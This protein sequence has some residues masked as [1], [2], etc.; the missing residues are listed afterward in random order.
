MHQ[1]TLK[2][3]PL[4]MCSR[5]GRRHHTLTWAEA[6]AALGAA[7]WEMAVWEMAVWAMAALGTAAGAVWAAAEPSLAAVAAVSS[8]AASAHACRGAPPR[9]PLCGVVE[10]QINE[11]QTARWLEK[12]SSKALT[13]LK[14]PCNSTVCNMRTGQRFD[15]QR[16]PAGAAKATTSSSASSARRPFMAPVGNVDTL[17]RGE[18]EVRS[19]R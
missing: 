3:V 8:A 12:R 6:A 17:C 18:E 4:P 13:Q 14:A 1:P 19:R 9:P 11:S 10:Q 5:K 2:A 15:A 7:V 16:S